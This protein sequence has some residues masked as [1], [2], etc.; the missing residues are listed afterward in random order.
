MGVRRRL[1]RVCTGGQCN[2]NTDYLGG[3]P[4][5]ERLTQQ[6]VSF[7]ARSPLTFSL[8][9]SQKQGMV[10]REASRKEEIASAFNDFLFL[11]THGYSV[12]LFR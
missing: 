2:V 11:P 10:P 6:L 9:A 7:L 3:V 1:E 8:Q 12:D 4:R 5:G